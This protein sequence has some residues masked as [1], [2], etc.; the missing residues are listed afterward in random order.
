MCV[1]VCVCVQ[2]GEPLQDM[3]FGRG[4]KQP[5]ISIRV[6]DELQYNRIPTEI[7]TI[8]ENIVL[9]VSTPLIEREKK[10]T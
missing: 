3:D 6:V 2:K 7:I 9:C 4:W 10:K 5:A 8:N 1:C